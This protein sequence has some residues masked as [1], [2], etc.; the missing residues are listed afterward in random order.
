LDKRRNG[1]GSKDAHRRDEFSNSVRTQQ[2]RESI[3][4]EMQLR[5]KDPDERLNSLIESQK[6]TQTMREPMK[7]TYQF[8][9]GRSLVTDF[10]PKTTRDSYYKVYDINKI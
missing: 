3:Q 8:D 5:G 2:Y 4:K 1:F 10:D 7:K 6:G 9:I